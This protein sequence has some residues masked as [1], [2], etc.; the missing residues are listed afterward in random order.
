LYFRSENNER[1]FKLREDLLKFRQEIENLKKQEL[2]SDYTEYDREHAN[3]I[4]L[5]FDKYSVLRK[6]RLWI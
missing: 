3:N 6:V 5:G 1:N 4:Q 2:D